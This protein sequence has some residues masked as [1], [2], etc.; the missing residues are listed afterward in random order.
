V[1]LKLNRSNALF[2]LLANAWRD[3]HHTARP[4]REGKHYQGRG[5]CAMGR[6][7]HARLAADRKSQR[8]A[9]RYARLCAQG[10][11]HHYQGSQP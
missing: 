7:S 3:M 5:H 4:A 2:D 9:R 8:R 10:R 6:R 1:N 11:K